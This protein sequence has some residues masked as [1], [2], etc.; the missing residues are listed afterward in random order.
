MDYELLLTAPGG[1]STRDITQLVRSMTWS[2]SVKQVARELSLSMA[3]PRDGSL[4]PPALEA[5][6]VLTL[7]KDGY[8]LFTGPLLS[9]TTDSQSV[10]TDLAA[11]D[12]GRF[13]VGNEGWYKFKNAT[14]EAAVRAMAGDFGIPVGALAAAG[15]PISRKFAGIALDRIAQTMYN[16]AGAQNGKRY[17]IRFNGSGALEVVEKPDAAGFT[18]SSTMGVTNTWDI[19]DLQNSVAIYSDTGALIRR[20]QDAASIQ[21]N[22]CLEHVMTQRDGEDVGAEARAW[23]EDHGLQ[24]KLTAQVLGDHRLVS[25]NAVILK[26]TGVGASGLFWIDA[27]THTWKNGQYFTKVTLNFRNLTDSSLSGSE[28]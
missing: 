3:V 1:G 20:E 5:G 26:D 21:T 23:L 14:P 6:S 19:R 10:I 12:N 15:I 17:L 13:L 22:G 11:L 16:L 25:G 28:L 8:P 4:E 27:D 18:I 7:R 24:Q 2:G 9:P